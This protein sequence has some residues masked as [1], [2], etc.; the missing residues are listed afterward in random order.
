MMA[1]LV[2]GGRMALGA[3]KFFFMGHLQQEFPRYLYIKVRKSQ[4]QFVSPSILPK[5]EQKIGQISINV[6]A[7]KTIPPF[8]FI[9]F[10]NFVYSHLLGY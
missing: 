8:T 4:K 10:T 9:D 5:K 6:E 1:Y 2:A 7:G 3:T